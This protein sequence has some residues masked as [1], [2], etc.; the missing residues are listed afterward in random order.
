[1]CVSKQIA[2]SFEDGYVKIA[3]GSRSNGTLVVTRTLEVKEEEFDVFL[4]REKTKDFTVVFSFQTFYQ[5]VLLLPPVEEKYLEALLQAEI[6]KNAPELKNFVFFSTILKEKVHE[7]RPVKETFIFAADPVE[8]SPLLERFSRCGKRVKHLYA[9][10]FVLAQLVIAS[11]DVKEKTILGMIDMEGRKTLLLMR[12]GKLTFVRGIQS[13]GR[14]ID[15]YDMTNVN[16]TVNYARQTLR[17]HPE[18]LIIVSTEKDT[19]PTIEGLTLPASFFQ[20]PANVF[21]AEGGT[22]EFAIPIAG[23][24]VGK[25]SG[26][27]SLLPRAYQNLLLQ[28][29]ILSFSIAIFLI[30]SFLCLGYIISGWNQAHQIGKLIAPLKAEISSRARVYEEFESRNKEFQEALPFINY[31]NGEFATPDI[32]KSL[33]VLQTLNRDK[34]KVKDVEIKNTGRELALQIKGH[35][36]ANTYS[37][38]QSLFRKLAD[39]IRLAEGVQG[40]S[41]KLDL[42]NK[43]FSVELTWKQ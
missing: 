12:E 14:G 17:E 21:V 36:S 18:K 22:T 40:V 26:K 28:E 13:R 27:E 33:V 30:I 6:R 25:A 34:V 1:M 9:D 10:V 11:E 3:Y 20:Y 32:Q 43:D 4:A 2:V 37:E 23:L 7:G 5:D 29:R 42:I 15:Q 19:V 39:D 31:L 41:E 24:F 35:I 38:L 8:I 16:M